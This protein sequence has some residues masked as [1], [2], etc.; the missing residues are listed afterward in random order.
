MSVGAP[1]ARAPRAGLR[2]ATALGARAISR[3]GVWIAGLALFCVGLLALSWGTWGDLGHDAG[4]DLLAGAKVEH[5]QYPYYDFFYYYGPLAPLI[6]AGFNELFGVSV[7]S[8]MAFGLCLACA[9]VVLTYLV[10]RSLRIGPAACAI[11]AGLAATAALSNANT[12]YV[13][14]HSLSAPLAVVLSL[15][16]LLLA[17]RAMARDSRTALVGVGVAVGLVNLTRPES[18]LAID[19][20]FAVWLGLRLVAAKGVRRR[21]IG[22]ALLVI[23]P[24]VAVAALGYG[25]LLTR[26]SFDDLLW[27]NIWPRDVLAASG[28][29]QIRDLAPLTA[30]SFAGLAGYLLAY[31]AGIGALLGAG[32][33]LERGGRS[34]TLVLGGLAV[35]VVAVV[36]VLLARP[37]AARHGLKFAFG[38][39]PAG[40]WM[41]AGWLAWRMR[42][43]PE[44]R[45]P[46]D[47]LALLV[48]VLLAALSTSAYAK[49]WPYPNP[50]FPQQ[51]AYLM[52]LVAIFIAWLHTQVVGRDRPAS[53]ALGIGALGLLLVVCAGLL[54]GDARKETVTFSGPHGSM[55]ATPADGPAYAAAIAQI[56]RNTKPGDPVLLAPQ[57]TALY[58]MTDRSSPLTS[59]S[60]LPGALATPAAERKAI[61][62]MRDVRLAI[63]DRAPL[64]GYDTGAFGVAYDTTIGAWLRRNFNRVAVLRGSADAGSNPRTLDVWKRSR[65]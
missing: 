14:P 15:A 53:R 61:H 32:A 12:S 7:G 22:Q 38:W 8:E 19:L 6:L 47:Q 27:K 11:A 37:E 5:G 17:H 49:F 62:D 57:M 3:E 46:E 36:A 35:A 10:G 18:A 41:A 9:A 20:A 24:A 39:V 42:K 30:G 44:S 31:A 48:V 45:T 65:P 60:L 56:E 50:G 16:A 2:G 64:V 34:R 51:T 29:V 55:T 54:I 28:S 4:Y 52:P 26:V 21:E 25:L 13:M 40:A 43:G 33:A 59:L 58:V 23:V 1:T 63:T